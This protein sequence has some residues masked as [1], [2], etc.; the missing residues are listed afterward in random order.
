MYYHLS[1]RFLLVEMYGIVRRVNEHLHIKRMRML[2]I[3]Q[4]LGTY[5]AL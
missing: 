5:M 2:S 4:N 1:F 3:N